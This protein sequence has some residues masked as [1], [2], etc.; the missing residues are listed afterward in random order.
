MIAVGAERSD[1]RA[2]AG[3]MPCGV[4]SGRQAKSKRGGADVGV[5]V[6]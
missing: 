6:L 1:M 5:K 3:L 4:S 2:H